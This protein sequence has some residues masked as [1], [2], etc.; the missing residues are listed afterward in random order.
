MVC[1]IDL[2]FEFEKESKELVEKVVR[3]LEKQMSELSKKNTRI[4]LFE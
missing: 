4:C 3:S 1:Y 2:S